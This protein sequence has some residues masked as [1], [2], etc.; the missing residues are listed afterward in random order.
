MIRQLSKV[1]LVLSKIR[2]IS[3]ILEMIKGNHK[4]KFLL[5][6]KKDYKGNLIAYRIKL[7]PKTKIKLIS[8][9]K[10]LSIEG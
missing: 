6:L 5:M 8:S 1:M 4:N 10:L 7:R 9:H 2:K 3:K